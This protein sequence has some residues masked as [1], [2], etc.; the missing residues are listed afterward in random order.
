MTRTTEQSF[1]HQVPLD[2]LN[3]FLDQSNLEP[4]QLNLCKIAL[5]EF[6]SKFIEKRRPWFEFTLLPFTLSSFNDEKIMI[7]LT[8]INALFHMG[9]MLNNTLVQK[10]PS[11]YWKEIPLQAIQWTAINLMDNLSAL[12]IYDLPIE[13]DTRNE[14]LNIKAKYQIKIFSGL[15]LDLKEIQSPLL[16]SRQDLKSLTLKGGS[17]IGLLGALSACVIKLSHNITKTIESIFTLVGMILQLRDDDR[18]LSTQS[19][20]K[21]NNNALIIGL[22]RNEIFKLIKSLQLPED[23]HKSWFKT[24]DT[25]TNV[26]N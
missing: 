25:F 18:Y 17:F 1:S 9:L 11:D 15:Q 2:H 10:E 26:L 8:A 13:I 19:I 4:Y 6:A 12:A 3:S 7:R 5:K 21:M 23:I 20:D 16:N 24:I 22:L 14:L